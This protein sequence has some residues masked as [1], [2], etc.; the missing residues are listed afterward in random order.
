MALTKWKLAVGKAAIMC[1]VIA[2]VISLPEFCSMK[3]APAAAKSP[4]RFCAS[5]MREWPSM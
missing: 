2:R 5:P 1:V 3:G 4:A